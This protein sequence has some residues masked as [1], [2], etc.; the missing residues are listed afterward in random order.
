[1][2]YQYR[3]SRNK[4][5]IGTWQD[6][7]DIIN[8][9]LNQDYTESKY[10]KDMASF[11][12]MFTASCKNTT[13]NNDSVDYRIQE[14]Q[15]K[16]FDLKKETQKFYDARRSYNRIATQEARSERFEQEMIDA[17]NSL[18]DVV[19][20]IDT[21]EIFNK[22][23]SKDIALCGNHE[24][25]LFLADWHYGMTTDNIFNKYNTK[26]C[27]ERVHRLLNEVFDRFVQ[28]PPKVLHIV[29]L[30][31][32]AHGAIHTSARVESEEL[33]C[34]Q[35]MKVSELIAEA[36]GFFSVTVK[37]IKVYSTYGNHLRTVQEK[38]DSIHA[39][40]ME[41]LVSW[42]LKERFKNHDNVE[43]IDS[44]FYEFVRL[45]VCGSNLCCV[46]GDLDNV[47]NVGQMV[48]TLFSKVYGD[49]IDYTIS[50]DKHHIESFDSAGIQSFIVP[51]LCGTDGY[52]NEHRLYS[53][54][55]QTL[56]FF[57]RN[58]LYSVHNI[59]L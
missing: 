42:W 31:D 40:N 19:P 51:A 16:E 14:I 28:D 4:D 34:D 20:M 7:A 15:K 1:M 38:K 21:N 47:K 50:A 39:D 55:G 36:I 26:I 2:E 11:D 48:N 27:V 52:A 32:C 24:A 54:P 41:K 23:L 25:V 44:D 37:D 45:N 30:G 56:M 49:T 29:L 43:I 6:V 58:G 17:A 13:G 53:R 35:I 22:A 5:L 46:H 18:V 33:V 59:M 12:K 3:I 8:K 10:R 9:E 57:D